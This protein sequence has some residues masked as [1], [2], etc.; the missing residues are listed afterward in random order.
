[1][2]IYEKSAVR[3]QLISAEPKHFLLRGPSDEVDAVA[4]QVEELHSIPPSKRK[5]MLAKYNHKE[6]AIVKNNNTVVF[7]PKV[8][9]SRMDFTKLSTTLD[10]Q[11]D[12]FK[13]PAEMISYVCTAKNKRLLF[14]STGVEVEYNGCNIAVS[15]SK[16]QRIKAQQMLKRVVSHCQ[17]GISEDKVMR[18]L[19]AS[20][21]VTWALCRLSPMSNLPKFERNLAEGQLRISIGKDPSM[22]LIITSTHVSRQHC[23]IELDMKKRG[24]YV[25]DCSTNG[26]YLNGK[27]LPGKSTGKVLLSH[28]DEIVL[29]NPKEDSEFGYIVNFEMY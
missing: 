4:R 26:T 6:P 16:T 24:I 14:E 19:D 5:L 22:D 20:L 17:W 8:S 28:G 10:T 13:V 27:R 2:E 23:V 11:L 12:T 29:K 1:M 18:L 7:E 15:G 25:I 21:K 9:T 3:I